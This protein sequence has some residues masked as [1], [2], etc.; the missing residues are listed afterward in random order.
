MAQGWDRE[1]PVLIHETPRLTTVP[2]TAAARAR[3]LAIFSLG[4]LSGG[5]ILS[6]AL[7]YFLELLFSSKSRRRG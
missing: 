5:L 7:A 4:G 1:E 6:A 2:G 3:S